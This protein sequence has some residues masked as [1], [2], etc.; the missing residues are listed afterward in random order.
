MKSIKIAIVEDDTIIKESL[1]SF[2]A[3]SPGME[4]SVATTS[5][6]DFLK[7]FQSKNAT[8]EAIDIVLLDI[9]LPGMSGLEGIRHIKQLL[10][11]VNIIM[12][13]TYEEEDKIFKALC[14]GAVA[15]ISKRTPLNKIEEAI[16]TIYSGGSYMSPSIARKVMEHFKPKEEEKQLLTA[17]Q[18]QIVNGVVDGLSYK[19]IADTL[20]ISIDTVRDHIKK[21][22]T[23]LNINSKS[24]LIRKSYEGKLKE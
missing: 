3:E 21:I 23:A 13:T 19:M 12:F 14:A 2:L 16:H 17:R 22:Y 1:V 18:M 11:K 4:I 7:T 15:Y 6:E 9:G 20:L 24:E 8:N 10:P 5:V